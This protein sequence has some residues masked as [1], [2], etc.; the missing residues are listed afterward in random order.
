MKKIICGTLLAV[1]GLAL[2]GCG[3]GA[4]TL[5]CTTKD[6]TMN[7]EEK[8]II[9]FENGKATSAEAIMTF[10]DEATA[11]TYFGFVSLSDSDAKLNGKS[12]TMK[13]SAKEIEFSEDFEG[14]PEE[15]TKAEMKAE[16]EKE[17]FTCK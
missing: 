5:T 14:N 3:N 7:I 17:G 1:F 15:M 11:S 13:K 4:E 8:A 12:I 10:A 6:E 2:T 9:T 16:L